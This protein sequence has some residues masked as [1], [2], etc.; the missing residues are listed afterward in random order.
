M[1][2]AALMSPVRRSEK[3]EGVFP[4]AFLRKEGAREHIKHEVVLDSYT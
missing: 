1:C 2:S 4:A 3:D